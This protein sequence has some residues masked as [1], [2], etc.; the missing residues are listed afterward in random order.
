MRWTKPILIVLR[1]TFEIVAAALGAA[2]AVIG[3]ALGC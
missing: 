1:V 2:A 3:A